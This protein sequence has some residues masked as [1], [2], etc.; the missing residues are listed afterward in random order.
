MTKLKLM[1]ATVGGAV[2]GT[3]G[4]LVAHAQTLPTLGTTDIAEAD[5]P[6]WTAVITGGKYVL[7]TFGPLVVW[8][9]LILV[10]FYIGYR[11][12]R[13]FRA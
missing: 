2:L 11:V 7:A 5:G 3:L 4:A 8:I 13:H 12:V 1:F 10:V 6:V 9:G